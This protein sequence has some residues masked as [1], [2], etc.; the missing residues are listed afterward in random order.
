MWTNNNIDHSFPQPWVMT[1][2]QY[3]MPFQAFINGFIANITL[4]EESGVELPSSANPERY[5]EDETIW[6]WADWT[7]MDLK[8]TDPEKGTWGTYSRD[9]FEKNY[10]TSMYTAGLT[11]VFDDSL[12]KT[13]YDRPEALKGFKYVIDKI[14]VE[15]TAPPTE[16]AG[17]LGGD[18]GD[19]FNAGIIGIYPGGRYYTTGFA[20]P[21]I[22]D[23][24]EWTLVPG[25]VAEA[26]GNP[27]FSRGDQPNL[28]TNTA[29]RDG[30]EE[31]ASALAVFLASDEY[32]SRVGIDRGHMPVHKAAIGKPSSVAPPPEGME[33]LK[34][35]ADRRDYR[36]L[37]PYSEWREWF[38]Q[39][40]ALASK[41]FA[42]DETPEESLAKMQAFGVRHLS[43][44]D[45]RRAQA[46]REGSGLPVAHRVAHANPPAPRRGGRIPTAAS[47][48]SSRASTVNI[49][50]DL[51][52]TAG[53]V[54]HIAHVKLG[55]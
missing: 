54:L 30:T 31:Q 17:E 14:F 37:W 39:T 41:A 46:L 52:D 8:M 9:D 42:G 12:T 45:V 44:Y 51:V 26:G 5:Y 23:R 48:E 10:M 47:A 15:K 7:E 1:G 24:F 21:R 50:A 43:T 22:K 3:G 40:R 13:M 2:P 6:T 55:S 27:A 36:T 32:Q 4:A 49:R 19:P 29:K 34:V 11:K 25:P 18:F 20:L 33:W 38:S 35:A 28:V 16:M 53:L